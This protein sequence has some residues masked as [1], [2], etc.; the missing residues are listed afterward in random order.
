MAALS[1]VWLPGLL[2]LLAVGLYAQ[3]GGIQAPG[4]QAGQLAPSF[5]PRMIL[6]GLMLGCLAKLVGTLRHRGD[7]ALGTTLPQVEGGGD[8]LPDARILLG[9]I[10]LVLGYILATD[11]VGFALATLLFLPTFTYLGGWRRKP[12]LLLLLGVGGTLGALV[13]FV[14][15]VYLPLPKGEGIF[16]DLTIALYRLLKFF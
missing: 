1:R 14:K 15:V 8:P 9:A 3:A 7:V 4:L 5:W 11:L 10:L 16:E 13:V 6:L 2:F 12:G